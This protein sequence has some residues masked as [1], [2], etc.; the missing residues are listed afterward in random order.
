MIS[1]RAYLLHLLDIIII[2]APLEK[3]KLA[4]ASKTCSSNMHI[5]VY[6]I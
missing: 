5:K 3:Q 1:A 4:P 2:H 6:D